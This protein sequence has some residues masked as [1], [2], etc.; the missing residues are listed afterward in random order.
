MFCLGG[1]GVKKGEMTQFVFSFITL[2]IVFSNLRGGGGGGT[3]TVAG[4]WRRKMAWVRRAT[5]MT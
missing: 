2:C 1:K 5:I 3:P 4:H